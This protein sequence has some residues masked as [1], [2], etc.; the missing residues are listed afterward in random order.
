MPRT[1]PAILL[2]LPGSRAQAPSRSAA[3]GVRGAPPC[4]G[5]ANY[6]ESRGLPPTLRHGVQ[7]RAGSSLRCRFRTHPALP[8]PYPPLDQD[9]GGGVRCHRDETWRLSRNWNPRKEKARI[10]GFCLYLAAVP[11]PAPSWF[12]RGGR[13]RDPLVGWGRG[14]AAGEAGKPA[15]LPPPPSLPC[16]CPPPA[17]PSSRP[18]WILMDVTR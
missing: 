2:A 11:E 15:S 1:S 14:W 6:A 10:S 5:H 17:E 12:W 8:G 3:Q 9:R 18:D 4:S 16:S 7:H 13:A